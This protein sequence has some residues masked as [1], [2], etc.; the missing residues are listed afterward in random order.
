MTADADRALARL[1]VEA[2]N[3]TYWAEQDGTDYAVA[4]LRT[5]LNDYDNSIRED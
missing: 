1:H 5:A 4:R 2:R 3:F